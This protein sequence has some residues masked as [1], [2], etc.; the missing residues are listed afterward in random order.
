MHGVKQGATPWK[1]DDDR[2]TAHLDPLLRSLGRRAGC[3]RRPQAGCHR[4]PMGQLTASPQP[5]PTLNESVCT[6]TENATTPC[7]SLPRGRSHLR[8]APARAAPGP[9]SHASAPAARTAGTARAAGGGW[10]HGG[11][12]VAGVGGSAAHQLQQLQC[13]QAGRQPVCMQAGRYTGHQAGST[14]PGVVLYRLCE[15]PPRQL[16]GRLELPHRG[17]LCSPRQAGAAMR[18]YVWPRVRPCMWPRVLVGWGV[19]GRGGGRP[20]P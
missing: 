5:P 11:R 8:G 17:R 14:H 6:S 3:R 7:R 1:R 4:L 2:S 15:L 9:P 16:H 18:V 10:L 20:A 19:G 12:E 13:R